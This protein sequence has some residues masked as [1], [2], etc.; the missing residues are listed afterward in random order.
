MNE[1]RARSAAGLVA[2]TLLALAGLGGL[3]QAQTRPGAPPAVPNNPNADRGPRDV[4]DANVPAGARVFRE[5]EAKSFDGP[6]PGVTALPVDI[7]TSK[8]FYKDQALWSDPRYFRCNTPRQLD[9]V[10]TTGRIGKTPPTSMAWSE[11][12]RD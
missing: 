4:V 6:P 5:P 11:C 10:Y 12:E 7:A 1:F 3:A 9:F 8:N 2:A